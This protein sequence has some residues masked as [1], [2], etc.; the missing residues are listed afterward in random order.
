MIMIN[1]N[2]SLDDLLSQSTLPWAIEVGSIMENVGKSAP[3]GSN[4]KW[5][6]SDLLCMGRRA[7]LE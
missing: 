1:I 7:T 2:N 3:E 6:V 4:L 5:V